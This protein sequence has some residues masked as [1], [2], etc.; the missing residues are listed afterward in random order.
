MSDAPPAR[1]GAS[2]RFDALSHRRLVLEGPLPRTLARLAWPAVLSTALVAGFGITDSIFVGRGLGAAPLAALSTGAFVLWGLDA[3]ALGVSVGLTALVARRVGEGRSAEASATARQGLTLAVALGLVVATLG[4]PTAFYPHRLM[5][6][7]P[8]VLAAGGSYLRVLFA[9][10]VV[11]FVFHALAAVLRGVGDTRTPLWLLAL[12]LATNAVADP[13]LI[14]GWGPFPRLGVT[15]AAAATLLSHGVASA[16]AWGVLLRRGVLGRGGW[17]AWRP[18]LAAWRRVLAIGSP[19]A[20]NAAFFCGVYVVVAR[21]TADFGTDSLAALGVGH[22]GEAPCYFLAVGFAAAVAPLVGQSLGAGRTARAERAAWG[23]TAA[24]GVGGL[25]WTGV[26]VLAPRVVGGVFSRDE[27]VLGLAD[28]YLIIVGWSQVFLAVE[29][30]LEGA[31]GGAGDTVPPLLIGLPLSAARVPA[32]WLLADVLGLGA[33]GIWLAIS[34]ST[35]VKGLLL[36]AW[37]HR[38][39]WKLKAAPSA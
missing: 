22:K 35:V 9:G 30:V 7:E 11:L 37:F 3:L 32:A 25:A 24:A 18:R 31:F 2:G 8:D 17:A 38:G 21:I 39:R 23:A 13:I 1:S 19:A 6:V 16:I 4:A 33:S 27:A 14:F 10:C 36:A 28:D 26:L 15:G 20:L 5:G 12:A 29:V 34:G